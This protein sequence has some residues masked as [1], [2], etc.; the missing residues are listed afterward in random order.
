MC[1]MA[2]TGKALE[3]ASHTKKWKKCLVF[4]EEKNDAAIFLD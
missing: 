1:A 2:A 4:R 3:V